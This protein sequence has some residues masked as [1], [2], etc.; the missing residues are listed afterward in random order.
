[1][2]LMCAF[3]I[4]L[5]PL[6]L[7]PNPHCPSLCHVNP[8]CST[9]DVDTCL[10]DLLRVFVDDIFGSVA[11]EKEAEDMPRKLPEMKAE[12]SYSSF[13]MVARVLSPDKLYVRSRTGERE[14]GGKRSARVCCVWIGSVGDRE[15]F[16]VALGGS[17][18]HRDFISHHHHHHIYHFS[19]LPPPPRS[20]LLGPLQSL[21][22]VAE[23][24]RTVNKVERILSCVCTGLL[25]NRAV[26]TKALLEFAL[27]VVKKHIELSKKGVTV[28]EKPRLRER[29]FDGGQTQRQEGRERGSGAWLDGAVGAS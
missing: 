29:R 13:Q 7:H 12:K 5:K 28:S 23:L 18:E 10:S 27:R 6:P 4:H 20:T 14:G 2:E 9:G 24:R 15:I 11:E 25:E 22:S 3:R 1:M 21:L 8:S 19:S 17:D 16:P 26:S